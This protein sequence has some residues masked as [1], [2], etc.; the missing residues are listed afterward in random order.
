MAETTAVSR[1]EFGFGVDSPEATSARRSAAAAL[2][3]LQVGA[4]NPDR[5]DDTGGQRRQT[6]PHE[7]ESAGRLRHRR[8]ARSLCPFGALCWLFVGQQVPCLE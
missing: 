7:K 1:L 5:R 4:L 6:K 8:E 3:G 2:T